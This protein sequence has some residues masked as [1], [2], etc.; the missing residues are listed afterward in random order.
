LFSF[1]RLTRTAP[2]FDPE[3]VALGTINLPA[4]RY[5]K[6]EQ[7]REFMRQLQEKLDTL[8]ELSAAGLVFGMPLTQL[9]AFTPYSVGGRPIL[10]LAERKLVGIRQV[11]PGYFAA[12]GIRLKE[13]R[14]LAAAD[15]GKS[16]PVILVNETL[17][18]KLFPGASAVGQ[19]LL[20]GRNG[21]N[22]FEIVGVIRD[23]RTAGLAAPVPDEV[24]FPH[25]QRGGAF[26]V[27]VGKA[28][29]GLGA[30]AVLPALRRAL[31]EMDPAVAFANPQTAAELIA[32]DTQGT[33]ALTTLL[34]VFAGIAALLAF[35]GIYSVM[36]YNVTQRT[37][38]IGVRMALGAT[39]G[40]I[41]RLVLRHA[42]TLLALGLA[43][44]VAG[45][46]GVARLLRQLL[47]E[48]Q[49][50][51]PLVFASVTLAFLGAGLAAC[52]IP[53][54]RAMRVDP[55]VALRTE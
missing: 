35:V 47:F 16:A 44:G 54:R 42:G 34:G 4:Q 55:I 32:Q 8:P 52:L 1:A 12:L 22:K 5:P 9:T 18:Q 15:H 14:F 49:P 7:Q 27:M 50:F 30:A 26:M 10:P 53:A 36:A 41:L 17:A 46:F 20:F 23:V 21:E 45:A 48:V 31:K 29:P 19:A 25:V 13:G 43:L 39:T 11:T 38:E 40:N 2:G 51:D 37:G 3:R 24:Y 33:S 28:K 6:P